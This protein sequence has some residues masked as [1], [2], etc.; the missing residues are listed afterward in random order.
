[1]S[2]LEPLG[3]EFYRGVAKR[4]AEAASAE[5]AE[6]ILLLETESVVWASGFFHS[7]NERPIG[8]LVPAIGDPVLF[9]PHL[10]EENAAGV[11]A[12]VRVYEEFPGTEHP[13]LWM[14]REAG[15]ACLAVDKVEARLADALRTRL[16]RLVLSNAA[17]GLRAVKSEDEL[18][19]VRAAARYADLVL[20]AV[21]AEAGGIIANGGTERDILACGLGAAQQAMQA[22]LG[23]LID[24]TRCGLT[25]TVH[26]GP[27]AA[28]P[29]GK[30]MARTPRPG[31][32][33]IAG[34]GA[35][36]AGYHAESGA[37]FVV[38]EPAGDTLDCLHAAQRA[39]AA[40]QAALRPG[41]TCAS[42]NEAALDVLRAAG[43]GAAI[44]HRI[45]HGMGIAGHEAPWLAPGDTTPIAPGMVFSSEP[46]IYRPGRDGTRTINTLIV[47]PGGPEVASR[48]Q[49]DHPIDARI[50]AHNG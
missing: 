8:L 19:F 43:F 49:A 44:R 24:R 18:A 12:D 15:V 34:I 26:S 21:H 50:L 5:G 45:G 4:L 28:L 23:D 22:E 31:E 20:E 3:P 47:G 1:M 7:A 2:P 41:A 29:H 6:A 39:D 35:S 32:T 33:L 30:T 40:A 11:V 17:T 36:V 38:G 13:V 9:V 37:T 25:G 46:G 10:E 14:A 16:D 27:R 48:F 42:V